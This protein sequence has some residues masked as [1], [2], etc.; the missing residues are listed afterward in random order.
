MNQNK[1]QAKATESCPNC[2]LNKI[3]TSLQTE[4]FLHGEG[5]SSTELTAVVP[6]RTCDSCGFQ[7]HDETAERLYHEAVCKH[8]GVMPPDEIISLRERYGLSRPE[9]ARVTRLGLATLARW[10]RGE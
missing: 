7:Y 9:F 4:S 6:L 3:S 10:E 8:L 5:R 2:G 1:N